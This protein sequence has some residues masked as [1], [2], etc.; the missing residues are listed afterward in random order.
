MLTLT[1]K[2]NETIRIGDDICI[3]VK[4]IDDDVV[5]IG[6]DAPREIAIYRGEIYEDIQNRNLKAV[7]SDPAKASDLESMHFKLKGE[8]R[9]S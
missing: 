4:R 1:R 7:S 2:C 3:Y 6:I 8:A 9:K 5:R